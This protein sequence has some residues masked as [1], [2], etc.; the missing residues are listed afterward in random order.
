MIAADK[1]VDRCRL[2]A[3][4]IVVH[5][6]QHIATLRKLD[7]ARSN[8]AAVAG[9]AD[10]A[11]GTV[12]AIAETFKI[13]LH[14]RR[15]PHRNG[16]AV[17]LNLVAWRHLADRRRGPA[18]RRHATAR[19]EDIDAAL[20]LDP[21]RD[22]GSEG[23]VLV[24]QELGH[25][26]RVRR[27]VDIEL[28]NAVGAHVPAR[29]EQPCEVTAMVVMQMAEK[30]VSDIDCALAGLQQPVVGAGAVIHHNTSSPISIR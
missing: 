9:V 23:A 29:Q 17:A 30:D 14:M 11:F 16:P 25:A 7:N 6:D 21:R 26:P 10:R 2:G 15:G 19:N 1:T 18:A 12:D 4:E 20:M 28:R 5:V 8:A 22:V 3:A 13:R 27:A 24:E